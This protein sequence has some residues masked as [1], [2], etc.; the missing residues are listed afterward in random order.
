[1]SKSDVWQELGS[2]DNKGK[3]YGN[4]SDQLSE[5]SMV[6]VRKKV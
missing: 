3:Q 1:M 6:I 2:C 5:E 4:Q